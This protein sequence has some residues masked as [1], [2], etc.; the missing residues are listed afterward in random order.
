MNRHVYVTIYR[1]LIIELQ[2]DLRVTRELV[3]YKQIQYLLNYANLNLP[4]NTLFLYTFSHVAV[5]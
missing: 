5:F 4:W 2:S 1:P 3:A